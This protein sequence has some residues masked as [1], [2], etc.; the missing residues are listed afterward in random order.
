MKK[1]F[2]LLI[3]IYFSIRLSAQNAQALATAEK[4]FEKSCL[5]SGIRNGFLANVDSNGIEFTEKGPADAKE[6]WRSLPAFEGIFSWSP[7]YSELSVSGDWGY[8]TGN[9][10]HRP[11]TLKDL[12]DECG[13]YTTLWGKNVQGQWKYLMDIGN[14]HEC[15][16]LDKNPKI[17]SIEKYNAGQEAGQEKISAKEKEFIVSVGQNTRDA[18]LKYG[19][20]KYILNMARHHPV[21]SRDSAVIILN[22]MGTIPK[23]HPAGI[24]ISPGKDMAAAYGTFDSGNKTGSYVRIWR[25]EKTGWKI[26]LEVIR[27]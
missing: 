13:Q 23:Y 10:E 7:S 21:T 15:V 12:P 14:A 19:S 27:G 5:D 26:A 6:F 11:K 4:A 18:Y 2:A 3:L 17:I 8:T 22:K 24:K 1:Y 9:Y 25:H 20:S 16:P